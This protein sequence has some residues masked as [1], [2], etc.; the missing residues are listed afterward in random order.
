MAGRAYVDYGLYGVINEHNLG[1]LA[2]MAEAGAAAFKLFLGPTTGDIRAPGRGRLMEVFEIVRDL[3]LPLVVHAEDRDVIEYWERRIAERAGEEHGE[4]R[5]LD[6]DYAAFLAPRPRF[7]EAAATQTVCLLAA[8]TDTPV[9]IAHVSIAEAVAVI[10]QA[11]AAGAPVSAED[12]PAVFDDD[13]RGLPAP[14][15]AEQNFASDSPLGRP[16]CAVA[17]PARRRH[18]HH[19]H[20]SRAPTNR[21][22]RT[23]RRGWRPRA[24]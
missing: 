11:K 1:E 6:C 18:R 2:G 22:S 9:H 7:G 10:R 14:G 5:A 8:M 20:R 3:G 13:G 4:P 21:R 12:V 17:G 19:R 23:D 24:A 15:P 16:R